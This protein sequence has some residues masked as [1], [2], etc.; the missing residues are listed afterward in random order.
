MLCYGIYKHIVP[1][2]LKI[3]W[4]NAIYKHIVPTG[5]KNRR[6]NM[7]YKHIVPTGL[8]ALLD[9]IYFLSEGI[10]ISYLV[11]SGLFLDDY[12]QGYGNIKHIHVLASKK[13]I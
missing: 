5:L 6:S 8:R 1:T 10:D 2:G 11:L 4:R 9:W 13:L 7:I 12:M 3:P